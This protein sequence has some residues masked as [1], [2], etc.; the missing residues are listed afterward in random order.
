MKPL[1]LRLTDMQAAMV[2]HQLTEDSRALRQ[3][4]E[5]LLKCSFAQ[6]NLLLEIRNVNMNDL[7][8]VALI[9]EQNKK[10]G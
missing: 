4:L 2:Q 5:N 3:I 8:L 7:R 6:E 1:A 10:K 9:Q